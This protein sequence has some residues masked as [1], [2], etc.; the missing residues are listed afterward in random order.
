V[1]VW[2]KYIEFE[3]LQSLKTCFH[4]ISSYCVI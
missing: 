4:C 2:Y 3:A 1:K